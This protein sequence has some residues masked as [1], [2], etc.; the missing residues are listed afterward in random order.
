M[1]DNVNH[2]AHYAGQFPL[3]VIE[4]IEAV[5]RETYGGTAF[6]AYC[7]GNELKYRF[8]AGHKSDDPAEDIAK[9]EKYRE[10]REAQE[11]AEDML[12]ETLQ[13]DSTESRSAFGQDAGLT[14]GWCT[15]CRGYGSLDTRTLLCRDCHTFPGQS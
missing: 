2:P 11:M 3:E 15:R 14:W 8:R 5:L 13:G 4:M 12:A 1:S 9:A 10:F 6:K 7:L